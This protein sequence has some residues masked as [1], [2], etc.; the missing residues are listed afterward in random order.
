[1]RRLHR[2]GELRRRL[3]LG[4][5]ASVLLLAGP[6]SINPVLYTARSQDAER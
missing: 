2:G 6:S 5:S 1:M 3:C 4:R